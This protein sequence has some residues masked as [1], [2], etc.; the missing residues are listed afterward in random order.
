MHPDALAKRG[1][2]NGAE[3]VVESRVGKITIKAKATEG[4]RPDTVA[5]SY[6]YGH[7]SESLPAYAKKGANPNWILELHTDPISGMNSFNDTKV[8]VYM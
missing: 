7:W 8:K 2:Q 5:I 6:H 4:I 3:V 1:I